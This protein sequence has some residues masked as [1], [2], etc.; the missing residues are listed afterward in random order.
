[1]FLK[2]IYKHPETFLKLN[3]KQNILRKVKFKFA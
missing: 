2:K 3:M 1:M